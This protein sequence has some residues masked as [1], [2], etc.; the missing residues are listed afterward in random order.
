[1]T[2]EILNFLE[3]C[4]YL[5]KYRFNIDYLGKDD[6]SVS[7]SGRGKNEYIKKYTDGDSLQKVTYTVRFRL[8]F[9]AD[10]SVNAQNS[11]LMENISDWFHKNNTVS[12][13][14]EFDDKKIVVSMTFEVLKKPETVTSDSSVINAD[15]GIVYYKVK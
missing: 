12:N 2:Q 11:M 5:E 10:R 6:Y 8:P 3:Q 14:P 9:G 13:F 1:M 4:P 7:I 15:I